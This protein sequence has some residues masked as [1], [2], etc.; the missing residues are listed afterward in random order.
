MI[1]FYMLIFFI[2]N[3]LFKIV[4]AFFVTEKLRFWNITKH[5]IN[6]EK[7]WYSIYC[8]CFIKSYLTF[9]KY[10]WFSSYKNQYKSLKRKM[11]ITQENEIYRKVQINIK[12]ITEIT[13]SADA[14]TKPIQMYRNII[15]RLTLFLL[16]FYYTEEELLE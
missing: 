3:I 4:K 7:F 12:L 5:I 8:I 11:K 6:W 14:F 2:C 16:L 13:H 1:K 15:Q 9:V 10:Y